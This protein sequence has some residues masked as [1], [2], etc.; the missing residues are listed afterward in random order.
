MCLCCRSRDQC[1][2]LH[3]CV[4]VVGLEISVETFMDVLDSGVHVCKLAKHIQSKAEQS[5][6]EG[7]LTDVNQ[8]SD[9]T[10][11]L[12]LIHIYMH[13]YVRYIN[14]YLMKPDNKV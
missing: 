3:G 13:I 7:N 10:N 9:Y 11:V 5:K 4:C 8:L 2:D 6:K 1:G 12:F 14:I